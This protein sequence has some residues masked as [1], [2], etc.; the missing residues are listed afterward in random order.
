MIMQIGTVPIYGGHVKEHKRH[1]EM[2]MPF[3]EDES[4]WRTTKEWMSETTSTMGQEKNFELPWDEILK[5]LEPHIQEYL[6][7]FNPVKPF[8]FQSRPWLNKY[9]KGGWQEQH[10]HTGAA[11]H[12]SMAY[13]LDSQDQSNFVFVDNPGNWYDNMWEL[14]SL[15]T[16]W[17]HRNFTPDQEDG[18]VLIF[19]C[20]LDH[21]VMPNRSENYRIT[22]SANFYITEVNDGEQ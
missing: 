17:P 2:L 20:A 21:F 10:N 1:L 7:I 13:I 16:N 18:T 9:E 22:A 11:S 15:F 6:S 8:N 4:Y 19:P 14:R 3:I 5:D 12:F